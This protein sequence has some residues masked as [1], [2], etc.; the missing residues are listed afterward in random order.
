[1]RLGVQS[2][3]IL[4][5]I[6]PKVRPSFSIPR[7]L[8]L[9]LAILYAAATVIYSGSWAF[10]IRAQ[11]L[12]QA[13]LKFERNESRQQT[14]VTEVVPGSSAQKAGFQVGDNIQEVNH[15]PLVTLNS[16]YDAVWRG[17]P[18]DRVAFAV[19]R[20]GVPSPITLTATLDP[21]LPTPRKPPG[22]A[23]CV[24]AFILLSSS[25]RRGGTRGALPAPRQP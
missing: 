22:A 13:G 17:Q 4:L 25:V 8:L 18:G 12:A 19:R 6:V 23:I 11:R 15:R 5:G 20:P 10:Y 9:G 14:L 24:T 1:V 7:S 2:A 16:F 21:I 3:R